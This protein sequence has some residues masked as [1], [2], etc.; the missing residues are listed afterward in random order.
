VVGGAIGYKRGVTRNRRHLVVAL[1][2]LFA[3]ALVC[4]AGFVA[5][6]IQSQDPLDPTVHGVTWGGRAPVSTAP[7]GGAPIHLRRR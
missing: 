6:E 4:A 3:L 2:V 5:C 1:L 7:A